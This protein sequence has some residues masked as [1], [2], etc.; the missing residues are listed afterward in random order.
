MWPK[1]GQEDPVAKLSYVKM[2][3]EWGWIV[4]T[5][6]YVDD[7]ASAVAVQEKDINSAI[8]GQ[9]KVPRKTPWDF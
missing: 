9:G 5:G 8:A 1:P 6:I 2:F 3:K 4:G 7:I